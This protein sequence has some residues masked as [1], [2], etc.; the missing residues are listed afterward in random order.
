[1]GWAAW[2]ITNCL[3]PTTT[4]TTHAKYFILHAV[5]GGVLRGDNQSS[6]CKPAKIPSA[7]SET[8]P[9]LKCCPRDLHVA[10]V[11][12]LI[13]FSSIYCGKSQLLQTGNC[14]LPSFR[15][16]H[17]VS[18]KRKDSWLLHQEPQCIFSWSVMNSVEIMIAAN[19]N[20]VN[21]HYSQLISCFVLT[22]IHLP[23]TSCP[24]SYMECH[25]QISTEGQTS[26]CSALGKQEEMECI[27]VL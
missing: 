8:K 13:G 4:Q 5:A 12:E 24:C 19:N 27:L 20:L 1:M 18:K 25:A 11:S 2:C 26:F 23:V 21:I 16:T 7:I 6:W 9:R 15:G 10:S 14:F 3:A 17:V 22:C